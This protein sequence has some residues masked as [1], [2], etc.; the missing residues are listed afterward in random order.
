V[1]KKRGKYTI[2]QVIDALRM[3]HG[4]IILAADHLGCTRT[5]VYNYMYRYPAVQQ[6]RDDA[7]ER[8][9]DWAEVK[10]FEQIMNGDVTAIKYRLSTRA[11][12]RG[13]GDSVDKLADALGDVG[14]GLSR[15]LEYGDT[16]DDDPHELV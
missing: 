8:M 14:K 15:L 2:Q 1:E 3:T 11:K 16:D 7:S 9:N 6:A 4:T 10:L 13:Y 5:T 12:D